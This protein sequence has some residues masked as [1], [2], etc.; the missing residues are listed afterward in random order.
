MYFI[1]IKLQKAHKPCKAFMTK[2]CS[3]Q[4]TRCTSASRGVILNL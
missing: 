2:V 1:T 4:K 3:T